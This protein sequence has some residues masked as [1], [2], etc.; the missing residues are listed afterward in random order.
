MLENILTQNSSKSERYFSHVQ[1][2]VE[3]AE[4]FINEEWDRIVNAINR[5]AAKHIPSQSL[6]SNKRRKR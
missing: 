5:A 1:E 2:S 6:K 4:V 3:S